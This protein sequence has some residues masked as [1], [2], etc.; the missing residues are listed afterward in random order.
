LASA[1][2]GQQLEEAVRSKVDLRKDIKP[3]VA[4]CDLR[5]FMPLSMIRKRSYYYVKN[6]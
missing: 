5:F 6:T 3:E 4:I 1:L 2:I